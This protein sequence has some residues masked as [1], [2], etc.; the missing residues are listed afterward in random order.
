MDAPY[1]L[2]ALGIVLCG[3]TIPF[4][5]IRAHRS[6]EKAYYMGVLVSGLMLLAF[7]SVFLLQF[8]LFLVFVAVAF[9]ISL[10]SFPIIR[11]AAQREAA[12]QQRETNVTEP[13]K[14]RELLWWKGWYKLALRWGVPKTM[15]LYVLLNFG[16]IVPVLLVLSIMGFSIISGYLAAIIVEVILI[17]QF[18]QQIKKN[19]SKAT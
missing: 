5:V 12:K 13:L 7:I 11:E 14:A 4:I 2:F 6:K 18:Y 3:V 8:A 9:I 17:V 1:Y 19:P 10:V 15:G 16:I